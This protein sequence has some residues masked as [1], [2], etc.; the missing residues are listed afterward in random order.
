[1][2]RRSLLLTAPALALAVGVRQA[3]AHTPFV[4]W[5]IYRKRHLMILASKTDPL[6][7][8]LSREIAATLSTHLPDS[9]A[10]PSRAGSL[11]RLASLISSKQMDVTLLT[12]DQAAALHLGHA[13]FQDSGPLPLRSLFELGDHLLLSR[14]DFPEAH[15][16]LIART[17]DVERAGLTS[18]GTPRRPAKDVRVPPHE[19]VTAYRSGSALPTFPP[20]PSSEPHGHH[21]GEN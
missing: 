8:Q 16:Y 3:W 9:K 11:G 20:V 13:P 4:Q 14:A 5:V 17:L 10:R 15:A 2:N 12:R 6:A 18:G 1:M 19:G 21:H 7:D